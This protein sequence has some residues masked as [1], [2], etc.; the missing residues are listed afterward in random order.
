MMTIK[1]LTDMAQLLRFSAFI[2]S[3]FGNSGNAPPKAKFAH[4]VEEGIIQ[5][6]V[7]HQQK[8]IEVLIDIDDWR[9]R[10]CFRV[11][12]DPETQIDGGFLLE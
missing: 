3:E 12:E 10:D 8:G 11:P 1:F 9:A 6:K 4:W 2:K 7:I 5:G